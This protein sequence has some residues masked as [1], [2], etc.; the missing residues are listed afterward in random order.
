MYQ[1]NK[2]ELYI[3]EIQTCKPH[4]EGAILCFSNA[5]FAVI[6]DVRT[7]SSLFLIFNG[8]DICSIL[9]IFL[10]SAGILRGLFCENRGRIALRPRV[11]CS[12]DVRFLG[13]ISIC[14][15][16]KFMDTVLDVENKLIQALKK[17]ALTFF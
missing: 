3:S 6:F 11:F 13:L 12:L 4:F 15:K 2:S 17:I 7:V 8:G 14:N 1:W 16:P 10:P 5:G 9:I